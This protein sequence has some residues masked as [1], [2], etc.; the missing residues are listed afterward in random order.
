MLGTR[1]C[2]GVSCGNL[3]EPGTNPSCQR[4]Q[5]VFPTGQARR[6]EQEHTMSQIHDGKGDYS[7]PDDNDQEELERLLLEGVNLNEE[8]AV[9]QPPED[10]RTSPYKSEDEENE[11]E[12]L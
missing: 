12:V 9:A 8:P 4:R 10:T 1:K 2:K 6:K 11:L 5:R 3:V 7:S